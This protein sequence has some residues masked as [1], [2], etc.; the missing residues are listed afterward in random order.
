MLRTRSF[1]IAF[2]LALFGAGLHTA[3]A[4]LNS[5]QTG[6]EAPATQLATVSTSNTSEKHPSSETEQVSLADKGS[7]SMV[8][9]PLPISRALEQGLVLESQFHAESDLTGWVLSLDGQFT[10]V[11]TTPDQRTLISGALINEAGQ[12]LSERYAQKYFPK[13]DIA[14]L[15]EA[16]YISIGAPKEL[17]LPDSATAPV[18]AS[19][20]GESTNTQAESGAEPATEQ[21]IEAKRVIYAF[22]DPSCPFC[23]L[24]WKAFQPY[25]DKGVEIRW[26]P[27]A[28][29][30]PESRDKAA[31]ILQS[32]NPENELTESM[33]LFNTEQQPTAAVKE[34]SRR[35]LQSNMKLMQRFGIQGTPGL[36]WADE[37]GELK[38][39]SGMPKLGEFPHI[40][41]L[42]E[43]P[44]TDPGLFRFR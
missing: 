7:E 28:F 40:T 36:V 14:L 1:A 4:S 38:I 39:R 16:T 20:D 27:V 5:Q 44:Q 12:N 24:A 6:N 2:S 31:A 37:S 19:P 11:Y 43:Q 34:T 21:T 41:G 35:Q 42:P 3:Q 23:H 10:L 17:N 9:L 30:N 22:F 32:R 15:E 18:D 29:L 13:P 25:I 26:I 8:G 33:R